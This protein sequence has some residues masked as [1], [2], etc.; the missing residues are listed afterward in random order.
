M[1]FALLIPIAS[2]SFAQSSVSFPPLEQWENSIKSGST[3]SLLALYS[4]SPAARISIPSGKTTTTVSVDADA[5]FWRGLKIKSVKLELE[6]SDSPQSGVEQVLF[7]LE[8]SSAAS[9]GNPRTLYITAA[10]VWQEQSGQW[11]IV[12]SQRTDPVRLAPPK[13]TAKDIYPAG[14][15]AHVEIKEALAKAA[16]QHKRVL[17]VFGANW[18]YDCHVLDQAFERPDLAPVLT[19]NFEV[20]HVDVG[21]GDKNQDLMNEYQV[22]MQKGIP[23]LAV[24]ESDGKLLF[25]QKGGEFERARA[26]TPEDLLA[27]LNKWKPRT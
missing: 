5:A 26:L 9:A 25:S 3:S 6:K 21:E 13:D 27:F 20:V 8:L 17:V 16:K 4:T 24:L 1:V 18:C 10:Q 12:A 14:I 7:H 22:P 11:R 2:R 23:A 19:R 15:D